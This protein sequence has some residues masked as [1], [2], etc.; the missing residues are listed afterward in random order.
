LCANVWSDQELPE[1]STQLNRFFRKASLDQVEANVWAYG[2]TCVDSGTN[3]VISFTPQE[4][5][6][7]INLRVED[8]AN[9]RALG[10]WLTQIVLVLG[11]F[12]S[13]QVPTEG[14]RPGRVEVLFEDA[15]RSAAASFPLVLGQDLVNQGV[16]GQDLYNQLSQQ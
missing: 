15:S 2:E 1:T 5:N 16:K 11:D 6:Y 8:V 3:T 7:S 9:T 4:M 14:A 12:Q 13:S 10:D